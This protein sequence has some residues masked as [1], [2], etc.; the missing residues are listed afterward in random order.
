[1]KSLLETIK[2]ICITNRITTL[3]KNIQIIESLLSQK[4]VIDAAVLGQFK[5]GKSSFLNS[6]MGTQLLPTGVIPL[7]SVITRIQFGERENASVTFIDGHAEEITVKDIDMYVSESKNPENKKNVLWV[8]IDLPSL[9]PYDGLRF[10]DT[11]GLGS[12]FKHNSAVTEKWAPE[13]GVAIVAISADRP[14]SENE[15]LLIREVE[16][17]SPDIIILLTKADLFTNEQIDEI[18]GFLKQSIHKIFDRDLSIRRYSAKQDS[19]KYINE[20]NDALFSPLMKDFGGEFDKIVRYKIHSLAQSCLS[21]LELTLAV[22][23]KSDVERVGLKKLVLD[24]H[25]SVDYVCNELF[26]L[27]ADSLSQNYDRIFD[28]ITPHYTALTSSVVNAF[29]GEFDTW[30]GNLYTIS[31]RYETWLKDTLMAEVKK[32]IE[33]EKPYLAELLE[34]ARRHFAFLSQ[35]FR[36][37]LHQS[38]KSVL[39]IELK[40]EE[41]VVE[42]GEIRNPNLRISCAND[43]H[44]DMLWFLFPMFIYR[45]L[46]RR[47]FMSQIRNEINRN[48]YRVTGDIT[49]VVNRAINGLK[50]QTYRFIINQLITIENILN[51]EE[52]KTEDVLQAI[53]AISSH[54][55][56]V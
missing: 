17:Y 53:T 7:T 42:I 26:K 38:V 16:K 31:R 27:T 22:S 49:G 20:L 54:L 47:Y 6:F 8:D 2:E 46:F 30:E 19:E 52:S 11:P 18:T 40:S 50:E 25:I 28:R 34:N 14:L 37:R 55:R 44:I 24:E 56:S 12:I 4:K 10:V 23:R 3:D 5:A 32:M 1:M 9:K 48:I 39:G 21:Y 13:I 15:I 41:W 35:S 36:D 43:F 51:S 33:S 29:A 45:P